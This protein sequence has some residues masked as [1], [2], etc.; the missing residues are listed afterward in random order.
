MHLEPGY[1]SRLFYELMGVRPI[2]FINRKRIEK[3]QRLLVTTSDNLD[4]IA[5]IVGLS[6]WAYL[7]RVFKKYTGVT[8]GQYRK[9]SHNL[10][11]SKSR[12]K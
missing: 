8:P 3:V 4:N 1:F 6:N 2:E 10:F 12:K 11:E 7:S 5:R 9:Q